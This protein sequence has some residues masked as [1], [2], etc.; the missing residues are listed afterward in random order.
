MVIK[1]KKLDKNAIIPSYQTKGA[2]GFDLHAI[3]EYLIMPHKSALVETGLAMEI[4]EGYELQIRPRSGL[5][6]KHQISV[7]NTPGTI[8]SDY[9]GEIKVLLINFGNEPF[10]VKPGDRIAQAVVSRVI[11]ASF[12]ESETLSNTDRGSGGFGSTG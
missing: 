1:V 10:H 2:A 4:E 5:A 3:K 7:L 8:D 12:I 6:L 11:Q 9:R